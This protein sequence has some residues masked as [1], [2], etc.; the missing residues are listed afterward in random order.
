[1]TTLALIGSPYVVARPGGRLLGVRIVGP[2]WTHREPRNFR[3]VPARGAGSPQGPLRQRQEQFFELLRR[4]GRLVTV[5]PA[6]LQPRGNDLEASPVQGLGNGR[7]LGDDLIATAVVFD[8]V[9]DAVAAPA[10]SSGAREHRGRPPDL[11]PYPMLPQY[12][13]GYC[14][15]HGTQPRNSRSRAPRALAR[16]LRQAIPDVYAGFKELHSSAIADGAL[17]LKVKELIALTLSIGPN[18]TA[19]SRRMLGAPLG[20][21]PPRRKSPRPSASRSSCREGR[22]QCTGH[23][24]DAF[25]EY[26]DAQHPSSDASSSVPGK[27]ALSVAASTSPRCRTSRSGS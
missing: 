18:A 5:F 7:Q 17:P 1:M 12:P 27:I 23:A 9:D 16:N 4:H 13:L 8:H 2:R 11:S 26:Y 21:G 24:Y 3:H 20:P 6:L 15:E 10:P 14:L 19:T 22:Q 25:R